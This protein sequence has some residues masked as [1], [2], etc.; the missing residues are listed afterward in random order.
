MPGIP[1]DVAEH[2]LDIRAR[3]RPVKQHLRCFDEEKHRA[4]GEE[5]HKLLTARF[6][7]E[8]FHPKWLAKPVLVRKKGGK[9]RMCIDYTGL[10]KACPKVPYPLPRIN[11]IVDSTAGCEALSFLDAY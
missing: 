6:I 4:I 11:Q 7:K 1:R 8:V 3:A 10:N 5:V 2:S 9:W